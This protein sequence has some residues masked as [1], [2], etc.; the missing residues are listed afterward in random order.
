MLYP[1]IGFQTLSM[2][3]FLFRINPSSKQSKIYSFRDRPKLSR[4]YTLQ[5]VI[6]ITPIPKNSFNQNTL[7]SNFKHARTMDTHLFTI[8]ALIGILFRAIFQTSLLPKIIHIPAAARLFFL[9]L[10]CMELAPQRRPASNTDL[11]IQNQ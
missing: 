1:R 10:K 4:L 11:D 9:N 2:T 6:F 7:L 8:L 3:F 5:N